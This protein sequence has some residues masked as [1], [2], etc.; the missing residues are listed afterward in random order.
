MSKDSPFIQPEPK[1]DEEKKEL[2]FDPGDLV[3]TFN[4]I[5][6]TGFAG[7]GCIEVE[8]DEDGFTKYVGALGGITDEDE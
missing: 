3:I 2:L 6:I 4:G 5:T 1:P 8:R 7:G